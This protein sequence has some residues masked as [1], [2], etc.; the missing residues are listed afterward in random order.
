MN[1]F[2]EDLERDFPELRSSSY[3]IASPFDPTYNCI[4]WAAGDSSRWWEPDP[5]GIC[6][7]PP[8]VP[9]EYSIKAYRGVFESL[10]FE[11]CDNEGLEHVVGKVAIYMKSGKPTHALR[12][13]ESGQW[14]SKMGRSVDIEHILRGLTG[15][16]YGSINCILKKLL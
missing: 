9:R 1:G 12:Q 5:M 10:G 16:L 8:E 6:Y 13:L 7:W 11:E 15:D 14:T 4:A 3:R 2:K